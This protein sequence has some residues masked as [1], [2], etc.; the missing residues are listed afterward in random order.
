MPTINGVKLSCQVCLRG[1]RSAVCNHTNRDLFPVRPKGRPRG[2]VGATTKE[3]LAADSPRPAKKQRR[4]NQDH[5]SGEQAYV[6][7]P[8]ISH[9]SRMSVHSL[10]EASPSHSPFITKDSSSETQAQTQT[11]TDTSTSTST[12]T[13]DLDLD[14]TCPSPCPCPGCPSK[15]KQRGHPSLPDSAHVKSEQNHT[16]DSDSHTDSSSRKPCCTDE[17][18]VAIPPDKSSHCGSCLPCI[19]A[20][21]EKSAAADDDDESVLSQSTTTPQR[22]LP[23]SCCA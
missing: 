7:S 13:F 5:N 17:S 19:I 8:P 2:A 11:Q 6:D 1:H 12:S 23:S 20:P 15:R 21:F 9:S 3:G 4:H 14:C 16:H 10:L 22:P 18:E